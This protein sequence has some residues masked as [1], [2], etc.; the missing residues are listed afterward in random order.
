[1]ESGLE[2]LPLNVRK[3]LVEVFSLLFSYLG[4]DNI[5]ALYIFGSVIGEEYSDNSDLDLLVVLDDR[6]TSKQIRY[7]SGVLESL[8]I[9]Y[10][11]C[12]MNCSFL[13]KILRTIERSTGMF[14]S[15]F[16][17]RKGDV[18]KGC[19]EKVFKTNRFMSKLLAPSSI[20]FGSVLSRIMKIYGEDI[21]KEVVV[22][23]PTALTMIK[24]LA[25]NLVLSLFTLV[26][27]PLSSKANKYE[28]EAAKW[29]T[30]ASYYYLKKG[31]PGLIEALKFFTNLG[32]P[33]SYFKRL[34]QLRKNYQN[35][36]RFGLATPLYVLRIHAKTLNYSKNG[37]AGNTLR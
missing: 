9:K 23:K 37:V 31:N 32:L 33:D 3:Y 12:S 2:F 18:L 15:H 36:I 24:S 10:G 25:M 11:L 8:E 21:L 29:S 27:F 4:E 34:L 19:F 6:I 7:V 5:V 16:V 26:I 17:C 13:G 22:S 1:M 35:D 20:V 28:M 14:E 30:L